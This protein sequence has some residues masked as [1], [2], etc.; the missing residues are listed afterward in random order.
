MTF[1]F[2]VYKAE[3][4]RDGARAASLVL[5]KTAPSEIFLLSFQHSPPPADT[6]PPEK[7]NE[8]F[9]FLA[10]VG[11]AVARFSELPVAT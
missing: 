11:S 8:Y 5:L 6:P 2:S 4:L 7:E 10:G 9:F 1:S 3:I